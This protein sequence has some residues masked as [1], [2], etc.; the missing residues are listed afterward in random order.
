MADDSVIDPELEALLSGDDS[1][2]N[3]GD[4]M[5]AGGA[6]GGDNDISIEGMDDLDLGGDAGGGGDAL[7]DAFGDM[8][9]DLGGEMGGD[10]GGGSASASAA[11][12]AP[13]KSMVALAPQEKVNLEFLLDIKLDVTFEV[14]RSKMLISDLLTLGQGSVIELHRMVGEELD[15][16]VNGRLLARGEVVVMNEKFSCRI[17][18]V[19]PPEERIKLMGPFSS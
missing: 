11:P 18:H 4:S 15:L 16:L 7:G 5:D 9:G 3:A 6:G 10:M 19:I 8:G 14:G 2:G 1:A 12:K 13:P 17:T